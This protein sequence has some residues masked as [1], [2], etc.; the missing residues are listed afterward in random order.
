[1]NI[2]AEFYNAIAERLLNISDQSISTIIKHVDFWNNQYEG[3][4]KEVFSHPAVFIHIKDIAWHSTGKHRQ[5]GQMEFDLHFATTTKAKS[6]FARQYTNHFLAHL[7]MIDV[8]HA[9]LAGWQHD[10]FSSLTRIRSHH[11]TLYGDII[12]HIETYRCTVV[13][14]AAMRSYTKVIGDKLVITVASA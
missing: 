14:T 13:D 3:D 11:D 6:A 10:S 1:M 8:I 4:Y 9:W 5:L 2:R 7:E 12:K